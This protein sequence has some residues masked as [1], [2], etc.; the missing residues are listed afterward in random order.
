MSEGAPKEDAAVTRAYK[1]DSTISE[2]HHLLGGI[3]TWT[4]WDWKGGEASYR[5]AIELNP[6]N[7]DAHSAYSHLL[8]ALG[9]S[10]E[11]MRHISVALDLDPMNSKVQSF[12]G[13]ILLLNRKYDDAISAFQKA[14]D[15]DPSQGLL[16]NMIPA[17]YFSGKEEEAKEMMKKFWKDPESIEAI[18]E[19]FKEGGF[20]GAEMKLADLLSL[21]SESSYIA[22]IIIAIQYCLAGDPDKGMLWLEKAYEEHSPNMPYLLSP[23][24]DIVR[25]DPRFREIAGKMNLPYK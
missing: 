22:S 5:K 24:F 7:A 18:D 11:A 10:D 13:V 17:L 19:G 6:Q 23:V 25:D 8:S 3:R 2:V 20:K 4:R 12:Y 14:M 9:R 15:L 1:L 21:R 16:I